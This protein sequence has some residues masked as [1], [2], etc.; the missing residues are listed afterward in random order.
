M[1]FTDHQLSSIKQSGH[2]IVWKTNMVASKL[3]EFRVQWFFFAQAQIM[4][5]TD[6]VGI[7]RH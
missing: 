1:V 3:C 2:S 6:V 7:I 5:D 4:T